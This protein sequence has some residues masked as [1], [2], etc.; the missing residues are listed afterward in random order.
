MKT[1]SIKQARFELRLSEQ[2]KVIFEKASKLSGHKTLSSFITSVV[3]KQARKIIDDHEKILAT[4]NDKEIFFNAILAN[5]E[6]NEKLK[7]AAQNYLAL[8]SG[9]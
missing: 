5:Y 3:R 6:P 4:E 8:H 9:K 2:E 1:E 7:K